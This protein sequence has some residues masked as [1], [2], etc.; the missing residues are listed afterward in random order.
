MWRDADPLRKESP[1]FL[2]VWQLLQRGSLRRP[3]AVER[4]GR[5]AAKAKRGW[6]R[7]R[8]RHPRP[9]RRP[10]RRL[11]PM[12]PK[13]G[14]EQIAKKGRHCPAG[15]GGRVGVQGKVSFHARTERDTTRLQCPK[16][17]SPPE[18]ESGQSTVPSGPFGW[19]REVLFVVR[20]GR[21]PSS[22]NKSSSS[23][24]PFQQIFRG[25]FCHQ[26]LPFGC[27]G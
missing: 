15:V 25:I 6:L 18:V 24:T 19:G 26:T 9:W 8:L 16:L 20:R 5:S 22:G 7:R 14:F 12:H 3:P 13:D 10:R 23:A 4:G 1:C 21:P 11:P 17:V 2:Y 27:T